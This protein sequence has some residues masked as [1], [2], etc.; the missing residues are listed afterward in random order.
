MGSQKF[1]SSTGV[2]AFVPTFLRK[3]SEPCYVYSFWGR[4]ALLPA[5]VFFLD[6]SSFV[7]H[8]LPSLIND[9]LNLLFRTLGRSRRLN[10]VYFLQTRIRVCAGR[11]PQCP[12]WFHFVFPDF[13]DNFSSHSLASSPSYA[14]RLLLA[15]LLSTL[16]FWLI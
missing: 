3:S 1:S 4:G 16:L 8:S 11:D 10:E 14:M 6:G 13:M 2:G 5:A 9:C 12:A 7:L 15:S